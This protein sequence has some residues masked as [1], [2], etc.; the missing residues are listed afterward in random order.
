VDQ[1][2]VQADTLAVDKPYNNGLQFIAEYQY[3]ETE[4]RFRSPG[5]AYPKQKENKFRIRGIWIW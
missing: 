4:Q 3:Q 1:D 2:P 5:V